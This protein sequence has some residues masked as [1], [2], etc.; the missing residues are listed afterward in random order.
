MEMTG[1]ERLIEA[2]HYRPTDRMPWA[3]LIDDYFITSL[4]AQGYNM[5]IIEAMRFLGVDILERHVPAVRPIYKNGVTYREKM[6]GNIKHRIF[7]TPVGT[8]VEERP[9]GISQ[10]VVSK[11]FISSEQ[12]IRVFQYIVENT[13][14]EADIKGFVDRDRY[15]GR[16]GLATPEGPM[17][18]IQELLQFAIGLE[19][20]IYFLMDYEKAMNELMDAIHQR[21]LRQYRELVKVPAEVIIDYEDTSTTVMNVHLLRDLSMPCIEEYNKIVQ[22]SGKVFITH[23]CGKLTGFIDLIGTLHVNGIDSV[24]PPTTGDLYPWIARNTWGN[25]KVILGGIEPPSLV[26]MTVKETLDKV[27]EI[28]CRMPDKTGFVLCTGDA[29]PHG[30]P[31]DNLR[32]VTKF[33]NRLGT[34]TLDIPANEALVYDVAAAVAA[35]F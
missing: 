15:I 24:C 20:T 12:D 22:N 1:R 2:L 14:Y 18:P 3:P 11:H 8:I 34:H 10:F 26:S 32:A 16:D 31:I 35:E 6:N 9:T 27:A 33:I 17:S 7:E 30:T 28:I 21:N 13:D 25:S 29:V 4:P 19:N 23:M 5:E